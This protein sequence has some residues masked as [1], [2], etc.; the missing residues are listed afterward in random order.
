[1]IW[2]RN[3]R[4][5][6]G[7]VKHPCVVPALWG[8]LLVTCTLLVVVLLVGYC[9]RVHSVERRRKKLGMSETEAAHDYEEFWF[10]RL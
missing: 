2:A 1:M 3:N 7:G 9:C 5:H 6:S 10:P 4:T 8:S